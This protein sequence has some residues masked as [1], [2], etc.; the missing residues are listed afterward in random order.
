MSGLTLVIL[1]AGIGSRYGGI[2]QIEGLGPSDEV[3]LDYSIYDALRSGFSRVV[4]VVQEEMEEV[5][6][7]RIT[8]RF[9]DRVV[10]EFEYQTLNR[11]PEGRQK[12]LGTGHAL[13]SASSKIQGPFAVINADDFYGPG[14]FQLLG[15]SLQAIQSNSGV[16]IAFSLG[17]TLSDHGSVSRAVCDPSAEGNLTG[18]E[19]LTNIRKSENGIVAQLK[20]G[21]RNLSEETLVSL[22]LWGFSADFMKFL[23]Q[24]IERF[25]SNMTQPLKDEYYLPVGVF[26]W[27]QESDATVKVK[28]SQEHWLGLTNPEDKADAVIRLLKLVEKGLYPPSLWG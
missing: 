14:S 15:E 6:R 10:V 27:I 23:Q 20:G 11:A 7:E 4:I 24:D 1:A 13:L 19:E 28:H 5:F 2:K 18:I 22:N 21:E 26:N 17:N 25:L 9:E 16:L 8:R 12:P 3:L